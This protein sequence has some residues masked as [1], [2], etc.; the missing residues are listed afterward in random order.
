MYT[1]RYDAVYLAEGVFRY[2]RPVFAPKDRCRLRVCLVQQ[3][4]AYC[5]DLETSLMPFISV[6]CTPLFSSSGSE[7]T[8]GNTQ[9]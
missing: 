5:L 6:A 1:E 7:W 8:A 2:L 4:L 3:I 9:L